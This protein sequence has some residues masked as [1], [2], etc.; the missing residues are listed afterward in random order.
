MINHQFWRVFPPFLDT[1]PW[2]LSIFKCTGPIYWNYG[3]LPQTWEASGTSSD[4]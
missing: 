4:A 2:Y 3:Y 1:K